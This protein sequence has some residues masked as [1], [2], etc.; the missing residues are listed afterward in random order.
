MESDGYEWAALTPE[1]AKA[2]LGPLPIHPGSEEFTMEF[3]DNHPGTV[4]VRRRVSISDWE[5]VPDP[6]GRRDV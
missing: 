5:P 6:M 3:V 1:R 4:L 2:G